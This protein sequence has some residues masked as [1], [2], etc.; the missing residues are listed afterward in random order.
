MDKDPEN[1]GHISGMEERAV[2]AA[3]ESDPATTSHTEALEIGLHL[4]QI[5]HGM[6]SILSRMDKQDAEAIDLRDTLNS[7]RERL[8]KMEEA[9]Q[10]WD[11]DRD[12]ILQLAQERSDDVDPEVRAQAQARATKDV[13]SMTAALR[14]N[15]NMDRLKFAEALKTM[16]QE[17]IISPG[18][19]VFVRSQSGQPQPQLFHEQIR[20]NG[21][22]WTLPAGQPIKV[23]KVVADR[24][25]EMKI[26]AEELQARR[27]VLSATERGKHRHEKTLAQEWSEIN[28]KYHSPTDA[29]PMAGD[30]L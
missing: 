12:Q 27:N 18:K 1:K 19:I 11:E 16:P 22:T 6:N 5:L 7:V 29:F 17:E 8:N 23:P 25:R 26:E 13:Q 4:D 24:W 20:I 14:A 15:A 3:I 30:D 21:F 2:Q 10:R 9:Q 28:T